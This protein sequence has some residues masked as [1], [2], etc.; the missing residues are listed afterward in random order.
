MQKYFIFLSVLLLTSCTSYENFYQLDEGYLKRRAIE[1]RQFQTN[2]EKKIIV[3]SAQVLQDL[4]FTIEESETDLGLLTASK[5]RE[6]GMT[7]RNTAIF[8]LALLGGEPAIMDTTQHI[9]ITMT[10]KKVEKNYTYARIT[11]SRIIVDSKN[12][13]RIE[14]IL[15]T[16]VYKEFFDKL[17]QSVFLEAHGI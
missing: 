2:D 17:S 13:S 16:Q 7:G 1:T 3:A 6:I 14:P 10:I 9:S 11:F 15:E 8:A 5:S 4:G 12:D